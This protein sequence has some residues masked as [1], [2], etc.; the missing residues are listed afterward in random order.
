[1]EFRVDISPLALAD[2]ENAYL[3]IR[4]QDSDLADKWFDGL[5]DAIDSLERFPARCPVTPES[6][7]LGM[8]IRQLLYGKSKRFRYRILFGISETE[9]N[10]YRIRHTAQQY[11]T[12]DDVEL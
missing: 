1:M 3:W 10:I 2:A 8:E 12:K 7:E 9:V 11:L 6:E 4:E 5:L